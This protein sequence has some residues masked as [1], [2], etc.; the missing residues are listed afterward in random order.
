M[1]GAIGHRVQLQDQLTVW[2]TPLL[3]VVR[4]VQLPT[5]AEPFQPSG[6]NIYG[7]FA[8]LPLLLLLVAAVG[9]WPGRPAETY[10]NTA[11]AA[12]LLAVVTLVILLWY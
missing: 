12:V 11:A 10:V 2:Q 5:D 8:P 9:A 6:G 3:G 1:A 7:N 4:R